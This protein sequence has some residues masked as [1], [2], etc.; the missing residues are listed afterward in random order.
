MMISITYLENA[1]Q[2]EMEEEFVKPTEVVLK[3]D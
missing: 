1:S 3:F 2:L